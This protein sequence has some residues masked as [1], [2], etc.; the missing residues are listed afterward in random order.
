MFVSN[1]SKDKLIRNNIDIIISIECLFAYQPFIKIHIKTK[2]QHNKNIDVNGHLFQLH[3]S[4]TLGQ[5]Y[6]VLE[7][8]CTW[9]FGTKAKF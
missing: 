5:S 4:Y 8:P 6:Q 9:T 7:Y 1:Y 2:Y 3:L